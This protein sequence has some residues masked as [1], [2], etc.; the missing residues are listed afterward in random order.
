[1]LR[2]ALE[3]DADI[4][5]LKYFRVTRGSI[6]GVPIQISRTGY[7]GDL[8]YELWTD[9]RSAALI[10]DALMRAGGPFG[11]RPAGLLALDVVRIE[12]GLLLIDVDFV[13]ARK[14]LTAA[15]AY[16]PFELGLGR[17][18][19]FSK[20][21]FIG[22]RALADDV[23][24]NP[25]RRV[26]G[27]VLEWR[28]VEALYEAEGLPPTAQPT[29]SRAAVPVFDRS[30]QVGRMTSSTWSPVLKKLIGLATLDA[31]CATAGTRVEVEHTVE[32]VRRRVGAVVTPTPFFNPKRKTLTPPDASVE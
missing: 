22:R 13:G 16:T 15:Q 6:A 31:S 7:T 20:E 5:A 28:E 30:R 25:P 17:L 3:A 18:V 32:G 24:R 4:D 26:T 2:A 19:D 8:G 23:T 10:W 14:A 1:V 29:A 11:L 9:A 21:R 12:A 27:L